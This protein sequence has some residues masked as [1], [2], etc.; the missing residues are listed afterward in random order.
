MITNKWQLI[1]TDAN[2][3]L[4]AEVLGIK[5]TT[6]VVM[7]NRGIRSK[8]AALKYLR[9]DL[10]QPEILNMKDACKAFERINYAIDNQQRIMIYGDYDADGVM[11]TVI[12]Y[13]ALQACGAKLHYYIPSREEEGYG[14]NIAA[15]NSIK[16]SDYE[17]IITCD[18]GISALDEISEA[19]KLGIDVIVIDHHEPGFVEDGDE[20]H[21]V[22]PDAFAVIDPKQA[23]CLYPFKEMCAGGLA[24]S[25]MKAYFEYSSRDFTSLHDEL[26]AFAA[27]STI[28]DIV[29][30]SSDNRAIVKNGLAALNL[31]KNLNAGLAQLIT[32]KGYMEKPI[33]TFTLGFVI[34]PCINATGRLESAEMAVRLLLSNDKNEQ[35]NLAQTLSDLNEERKNLTKSCSDRMLEKCEQMAEDYNVLVVV[36]YETHESIAGIVAGRVKEKLHKP[37][38]LL[39]KGVECGILKGSGRSIPA[40]NMFEALYANR[41]LFTRFGGH[42]MAAGLSINEDKVAELLQR[43]NADFNLSADELQPFIEIDMELSPEDVTL[44]L[45]KELEYLSPFG[46][47]NR[48]AIFS[49]YAMPVSSLRI[50]DNKNT[51]IFTFGNIKAIAFGLNDVFLNRLQ[52]RYTEQAYRRIVSGDIQGLVMDL[53]YTVE[54]NTYNGR[55]SV[56][57][58]LKDFRIL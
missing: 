57:M 45:S 15:I 36:D 39:T 1:E 40:Y 5:K 16:A 30:L 9:C 10:D 56:Q 50:I 32:L 27:I 28:C 13:K 53:A 22:I 20:R 23:D 2:L 44:E 55:T 34:G 38:I 48:E 24:F 47:G 18:N 11:S 6:A 8:K 49:S 33:D 26:L 17:L 4:M 7:A 51:L 29:D 41:D 43:L 52:E 31:N 19:N 3:D 12:L 46:R 25:L 54:T 14:L 58:R 42:S 37:V 21:D 35:I